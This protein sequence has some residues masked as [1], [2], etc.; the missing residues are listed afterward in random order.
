MSSVWGPLKLTFEQRCETLARI[1]YQSM[2]LPSAAQAP[3]MKK[4]GLTPGMMTGTGTSFQNGVI[5]KDI[6]AGRMA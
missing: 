4:Y 2:D 3:L 1:G 5:R 6:F